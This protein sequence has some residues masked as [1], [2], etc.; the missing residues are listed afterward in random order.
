MNCKPGDLAIVVSDKPRYNGRIVEVLYSAPLGEFTLP[1]GKRHEPS[2]AH[3]AWIIKMI[4]GPVEAPLTNGGSRQA[5]YG[6]G[7]DKCLRP[8]RGDPD[9]VG[10]PRET[11]VTT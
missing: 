3:P 10:E 2:K 8:L 9:E 5:W 1:D 7:S 4:G 6:V 11:E